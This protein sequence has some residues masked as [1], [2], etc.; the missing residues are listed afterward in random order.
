MGKKLFKLIKEVVVWALLLVIIANIISYFRRPDLASSGLP[1]FK[2]TLIDGSDFVPPEGKP[3][4]IHFWGT[5]CPVCRLEADNIQRIANKYEV[6]TI[7]VSS[8]GDNAIRSYM[9]SRNLSFRVYNDRDGKWAKSF[10]VK[11]FPTSFIYDGAGQ[12]KFSEV[13]YT[14]TLGLMGRLALID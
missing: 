3:L 2:V 7:A 6:L 10:Q 11:V 12:L 4:V 14:S 1:P 13:G 5:W 8:G 9:K